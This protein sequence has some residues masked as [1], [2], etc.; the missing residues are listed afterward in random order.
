MMFED[1]VKTIVV[2]VTEKFDPKAIIVF[3]SV[4][5]GDSS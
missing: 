5:R 2:R 1:K 4:A 3:G